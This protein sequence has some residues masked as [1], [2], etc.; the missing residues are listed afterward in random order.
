VAGAAHVGAVAPGPE[1]LER[2][3]PDLAALVPLDGV[4]AVVPAVQQ[5]RVVQALGGEE[6]LLLGDPLLQAAVRHDLERHVLLL[7]RGHSQP[8]ALA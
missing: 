2:T 3:G 7:E 8:N 5:E 6:T 1:R 4:N